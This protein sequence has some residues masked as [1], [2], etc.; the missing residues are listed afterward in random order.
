MHG[1]CLG[2]DRQITSRSGL[3]SGH[4]PPDN[5]L[6]CELAHEI[7][8]EA[9]KHVRLAGSLRYLPTGSCTESVDSAVHRAMCCGGAAETD[10]SGANAEN[11]HLTT[12]SERLVRGR[13]A[14]G[15]CCGRD[16]STKLGLPPGAVGRSALLG[17]CGGGHLR[18]RH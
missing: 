17:T 3:H 7:E 10:E 11:G 18:D 14:V 5:P 12:D 4:A 13:Q 16:R 6:A 9:L 2:T 8:W 15:R 1:G